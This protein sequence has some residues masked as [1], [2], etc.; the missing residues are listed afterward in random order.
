M[1]VVA[2]DAPE[3]PPGR[4]LRSSGASGS[5][6]RIANPDDA[7]GVT[8]HSGIT[9]R[10][11]LVSRDRCVDAALFPPGTSSFP[12]GEAVRS[13]N[14]DDYFLYTPGPGEG[15]RFSV[16]VQAPRSRRGALPYRVT[17]AR[18]GEDDT[19]PGVLL[20]NDQRVSGSL[21]GGGADVVDLYRF[22]V[23]QREH[24]GPAPAHGRL[25]AVQPP[26]RRRRRAPDRVRLRR[27]GR[28]S[29]SG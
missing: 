6:D 20:A 25:D 15:G 23:R 28:R 5:V 9:Y 4:P 1:R 18:A 2:P 19:A 14:C 17:V 12:A 10:V 24:P 22:S 16:Q 11:H 29:R 21:R 26:A 8:M 3:R 27:R 13:F 7:Y